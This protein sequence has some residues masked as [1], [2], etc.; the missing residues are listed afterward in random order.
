MTGAETQ[1]QKVSGLISRRMKT[2]R[3]ENQHQDTNTLMVFKT[4]GAKANLKMKYKNTNRWNYKAIMESIT[5]NK[6]HNYSLSCSYLEIYWA[7]H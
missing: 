5:K 3:R 6:S 4:R 1:G 7:Y 2:S